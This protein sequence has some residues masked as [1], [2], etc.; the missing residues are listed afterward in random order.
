MCYDFRVSKKD[1]SWLTKIFI[2]KFRLEGHYK[3]DG[4]V[5]LL[6]LNGEGHFFIEIGKNNVVSLHVFFF[7]FFY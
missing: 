3:M 7:F 1:F 4:R 2:P 6:P 5:L